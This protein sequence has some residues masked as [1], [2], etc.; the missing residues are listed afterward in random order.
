MANKNKINY[1]FLIFMIN[2]CCLISCKSSFISKTPMQMDLDKFWSVTKKQLAAIPMEAKVEPVT[3]AIPY[4]KLKVTLRS[5][6]GV[7]IT[8]FLSLPIQGEIQNSKP[9]PVIVTT[10]G[11]GGSQQGVMLSECQ[12]GFAILQVFPRGQGESA[13][14]YKI[15]GD[16]L[17]G[18]LEHPEGA[19]YQGAYADVMRM[20]D[21][22]MTRKDLDS[23]RIALAG[24]SQG[25]GFSLA[26]AALDSRVKA[27][28]AHVPFLCNFRL[29]A[30]TKSLVKNLLD[31]AAANNE[32]SFNT[33]DY[34]DP[35]QLAAK[36][37]I[38]VLISAGGK[39]DVCPMPTIQS[40]Y[41]QVKGKKTLKIYPELKHT[42]CLDFYNESWKWLDKNFTN[43]TK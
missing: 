31:K 34:F 7:L 27:V 24:T 20:I 22:V 23:N 37:H 36:I 33:L 39:D 26:V 15:E 16:K 32:T 14:F 35:L 43:K 9:W 30:Q 38:P 28:V 3:E 17:T 40:V 1:L 10:P 5:F 21:F 2:A 6:E 41:K 18:H 11:Y 29:A 8:A 4:R 42:S 25:G 12:R 13:A 19:Y